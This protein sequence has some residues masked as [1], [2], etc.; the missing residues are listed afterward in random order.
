MRQIL[1][2][3]ILIGLLSCK[4]KVV[5]TDLP[6]AKIENQF[7][8]LKKTKE[9]KFGGGDVWGTTYI[10][11][12]T[13]SS[14]T[15]VLVDYDAGDYG[16]GRNEYLIVD[17]R[18]IYQRD[19]IVDQVINKSPLDS[20]EYK[21]RETLCYFNKDSTGTKTSKAV[22]SMTMDFD[23]ERIQELKNK[24]ADSLVLTKID[25]LKMLEELKDALTRTVI[26]D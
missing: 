15:K 8:D 10:F 1:T 13:D 12:N 2:T 4:E 6:V 5:Q 25:Y 19:S 22:Y 9:T 16:K 21:L 11:N 20:N 18:L 7:K 17:S 24:K 26:E 14:V 23:S 3:L